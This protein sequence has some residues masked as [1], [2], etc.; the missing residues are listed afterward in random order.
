LLP[1]V[2][3]VFS[4]QF[5]VTI[6]FHYGIHK[7][8]NLKD[9]NKRMEIGIIEKSKKI[10]VDHNVHII[11]TDDAVIKFLSHPLLGI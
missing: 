11:L 8:G 9:E 3:S 1:V 4:G 10:K 7:I 2:N 5:L 6:T